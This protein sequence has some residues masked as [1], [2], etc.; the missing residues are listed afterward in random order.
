[1]PR[2]VGAVR[3]SAASPRAVPAAATHRVASRRV[4]GLGAL[5][6]RCDGNSGNHSGILRKWSRHVWEARRKL[7]EP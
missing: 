1:M 3:V 6:R 2:C 4:W 7:G 5:S